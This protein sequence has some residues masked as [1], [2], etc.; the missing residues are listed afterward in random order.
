[1]VAVTRADGRREE[2]FAPCR[3]GDPEAPL[4]DAEIDAK[5]AELAAPVLG[6][7]RARDLLAKLWRL[8]SLAVSDLRLAAP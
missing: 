6:E 4:T 2:H 1:S 8:E 3:K 5:F 7:A